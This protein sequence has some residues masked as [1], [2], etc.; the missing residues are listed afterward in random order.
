M[1][2]RS[3]HLL[4]IAVSVAFAVGFGAWL[5]E[6]YLRDGNVLWILA[7]TLCLAC[8]AGM[9]VYG[10]RFSRKTRHLNQAGTR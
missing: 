7:V 5:V 8:A 1:S 4:F 9:V 6:N 2:L 10:V 3:F